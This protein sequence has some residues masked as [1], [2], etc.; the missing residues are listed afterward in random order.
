MKKSILS[1]I[2]FCLTFGVYSQIENQLP[3]VVI[4]AVN[5]KYLNAVENEEIDLSVQMLQE[6]V[7]MY[8][9][10]NSE[11]YGDEYETYT[12]SFFIPDGKILAAYDKN[13]KIIRT[14][15]KFKN[16][17][18]P[19]SVREAVYKRFP[20]WSL[21]KDV[22]LVNYHSKN[23]KV[24]KEYKVKLKNGEKT[25]RVKLTEDGNFM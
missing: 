17:K 13:G 5:Y 18:L 24:S 15:E 11:L 21:E 16:I 22:Y 23:E 2:I 8:D 25:M 3:E 12:V 10:K 20:N 14:I 19:K 6:Q 9:L 7:A 1:L 4:T